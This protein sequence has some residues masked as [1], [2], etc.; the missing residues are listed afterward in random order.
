M[1][2][3][4]KNQQLIQQQ[5]LVEK[6]KPHYALRKLSIGVASVLLGTT[7]Y[8]ASA[9]TAQADTVNSASDATNQ[10]ANNV[11][12]S[13]STKATASLQVAST[14]QSNADNNQQGL[15]SQTTSS[16]VEPDSQA[17]QT[18]DAP[19]SE[20]SKTTSTLKMDDHPDQVINSRSGAKVSWM[21]TNVDGNKTY[22]LDIPQDSWLDD[23]RIPNI[24]D[25]VG[26][27]DGK[28]F[29]DTNGKISGYRLSFRP[30]SSNTGTVTLPFS[31]NG[32]SST[33]DMRSGGI[34][35]TDAAV[36]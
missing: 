15:E 9:A 31:L 23:I 17:S 28:A 36:N 11:A 34:N 7:I 35:I 18:S 14:A 13:D 10:V 22:Y 3:S 1:K 32:V 24:S 27:L 29:Q 2:L 25:T 19:V 21:L 33:L 16:T 5:L 30:T 26:R 4:K 6:Q 8:M 12:D 20:A